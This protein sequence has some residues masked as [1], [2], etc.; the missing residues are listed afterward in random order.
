MFKGDLTA[1]AW[2]DPPWSEQFAAWKRLP[3]FVP[4]KEC[5]ADGPKALAALQNHHRVH[6]VKVGLGVAS[7]TRPCKAAKVETSLPDLEANG[8]VP[9]RR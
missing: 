8:A 9:R 7:K 1:A 5:R 4:P 3:H 6:G 2:E